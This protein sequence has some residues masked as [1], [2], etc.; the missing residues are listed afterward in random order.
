MQSTSPQSFAPHPCSA[1]W[2]P[3]SAPAHP[4]NTRA[5]NRAK[6]SGR[7]AAEFHQSHTIVRIAKRIGGPTRTRIR[8]GNAAVGSGAPQTGQ[9]K[10][11]RCIVAAHS[12]QMSSATSE[13]RK[14]ARQ[15]KCG[16]MTVAILDDQK[17]VSASIT[18]GG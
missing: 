3:I 12:L 4:R 5:C 2:P 7:E 16:Y 6:R 10:A 1:A 18:P 14:N 13:P 8:V 17:R 15:A 11:C 9:R